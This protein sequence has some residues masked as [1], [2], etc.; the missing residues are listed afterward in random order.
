MAISQ[1]FFGSRCRLA[2]LRSSVRLEGSRAVWPH[3]ELTSQIRAAL[4]MAL[5]L[6]CLADASAETAHIFWKDLRPASQAAAESVGLP[7]IAAKNA[8][9]WRDAVDRDGNLEFP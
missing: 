3:H 5:C 4:T 7:M 6:S 8:R 2:P 9:S 1:H